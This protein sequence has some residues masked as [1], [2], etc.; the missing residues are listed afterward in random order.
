M[1]FVLQEDTPPAS[2]PPGSMSRRGFL[3]RAAA[4]LG[5]SL[6]FIATRGRQPGGK[7]GAPRPPRTSPD[8]LF[9]P[10]DG[11]A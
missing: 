11:S 8:S 7:G 5:A 10:R 4:A 6:A 2:L 1:E 3:G 9:K